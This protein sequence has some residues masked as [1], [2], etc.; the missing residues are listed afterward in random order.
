MS[1]ITDRIRE[2][3]SWNGVIIGGAALLVLLGIMPLSK[4][5]MWGALAWGAYNIWMAE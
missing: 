1:W 3:T 4:M 2:R 5:V